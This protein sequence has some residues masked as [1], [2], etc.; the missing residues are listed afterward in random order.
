MPNDVTL[1]KSQWIVRDKEGNPWGPFE[2]SAKAIAWAH[3]KW[4]EEIEQE[5]GWDIEMLWQP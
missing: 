5:D 2:G 1:P 3:Q 4:P